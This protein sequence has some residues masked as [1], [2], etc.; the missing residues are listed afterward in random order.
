M[1]GW[2]GSTDSFL[3]LAKQ[4]ANN[5]RVTLVDFYGHGKTPFPD[6]ELVL[7]DYVKSVYEIIKHYKMKS[8]SIVAHSFGGRV[9]LKLAHKYGYVLDRLIL[10]DSAGI[11][12][13]RGVKYHYKVLRHK[14][15]KKLHIKHKSGSAD[16]NKLK[17]V[18]KK[19]FINI[20]NED[21]TD[22]LEKITLP[23]LII[24]GNKDKDTPIYM[25]KKLN[26]KLCSSGL[27]V[28]KDAGHFSYLDK[29]GRVLIIIRSFMSEG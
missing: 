21:L 9:A 14:L 17:G 15:L 6:R 11:K 1:H 4:L 23:T 25:A 3:G 22:I 20:V 24:W 12:P 29:P 27:V 8:V 26:R 18:E 28:I 5:F 16:Y 2:G 19:T 13:R 10:I 7:D